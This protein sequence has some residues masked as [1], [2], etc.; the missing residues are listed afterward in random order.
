MTTRKQKSGCELNGPRRSRKPVE[1]LVEGAQVTGTD[2]IP[3]I[4][5]SDLPSEINDDLVNKLVPSVGGEEHPAIRTS[6]SGNEIVHKDNPVV[7]GLHHDITFY[8]EVKAF[9]STMI[10]FGMEPE[11]E[12]AL[13]LIAVG[14]PVLPL[15]EQTIKE[16]RTI[17]GRI[18]HLWFRSRRAPRLPSTGN[19]SINGGLKI[20]K[21]TAKR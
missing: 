12:L 21:P 4:T 7:N 8:E 14:I 10:G 13:D 3:Q 1:L 2:P 19:R 17:T 5:R 9:K 6:D 20:W 11:C 16:Q 18:R 15:I